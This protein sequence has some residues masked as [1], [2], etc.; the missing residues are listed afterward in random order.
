MSSAAIAIWILFPA[1]DANSEPRADF[2]K[3]AWQSIQD[4]YGEIVHPPF[5][6]ELRS[7]SLDRDKF[8]FYEEQDAFYLEKYSKVLR[9]LARRVSVTFPGIRPVAAFGCILLLAN[10]LGVK[11][12]IEL[13]GRR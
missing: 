1:A 5:N 9:V 4:T 10:S 6:V 8:R 2:S 11:L 7:G 3:V 13:C 12:P